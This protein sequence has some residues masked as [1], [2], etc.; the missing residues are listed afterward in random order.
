MERFK[1]RRVVVSGAA[2]DVGRILCRSFVAEGGEVLGLD[3]D[4]EAG[5]ALAAEL[6]G[7]G[8]GSFEFKPLDL[9]DPTAVES[10]CAAES[11]VDVIVNNA[12]ILHIRPLAEISVEEW[13]RVQEVDLR[14]AFLLTR[15]LAGALTDGSAI[16]NIS[17]VGAITA[18]GGYAAYSSAKA[19]LIALSREAAAEM[20]P[21]TRVNTVVPG[22]LDTAMPHRFLEGHPEKEALLE[23]LASTVMLKRLGRAEE[24]P[25]LCLFMASD[26]A[27]FMTGS[28]VVIDGGLSA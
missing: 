13:D 21:R 11:A 5:A 15:G 7:E 23:H 6:G 9:T 19:G 12:G 1:G 24:I 14:G 27:S 20:A 16:V 22:P 10:V 4:A 8:A 18:T 3:I 26:E 25:P 17:S 2:G 28:T